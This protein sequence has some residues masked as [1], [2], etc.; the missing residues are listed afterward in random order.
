MKKWM[1]LLASVAVLV[2]GITILWGALHSADAPGSGNDA[3]SN[4]QQAATKDVKSLV[5]YTLPSGWQ[6]G[7][8]TSDEDKLYL[9]PPDAP[10]DCNADPRSP[11]I[12]LVDPRDTKDCQHVTA[13]NGV[14]SH[15]CKSVFIDGHKTIQTATEYP[16]SDLYPKAETDSYYFIDTGKGVVQ[17]QYIYGAKGSNTY[18]AA[19][20]QLVQSFKV[21]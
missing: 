7:K 9:T 20:D 1:T 12:V 16:K 14:L 11:F 15:T 17:L 18:Q 13:P 3:A 6:E 8:C 10:L 2:V 4:N 21:Q 5:S 19:F